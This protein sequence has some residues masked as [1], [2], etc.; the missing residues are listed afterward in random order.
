[1]SV[2]KINNIL[3][4]SDIEN[5]TKENCVPHAIVFFEDK[6]GEWI[7]SEENN[8]NPA[9]QKVNKI[10]GEENI[11]IKDLLVRECAVINYEK[12]IDKN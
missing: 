2:L 12:P 10:F 11:T 5:W 4:K 8:L 1:M 3:I 7:T 6:N 9:F